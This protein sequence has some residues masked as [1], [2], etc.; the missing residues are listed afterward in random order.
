[1]TALSSEAL[2]VIEGRHSDP[3]H[4]LGLYVE[5]DTPVVRAFL[6]DAEDV[7]AID[8]TGRAGELQRIH[9]AGLFAGNLA[10]GSSHYHLQARFG[11]RV[12]QFEEAS[13]L[14]CPIS[15]FTSSARAITSS[16]TTNSAP[17]L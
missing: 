10:N 1:M 5:G 15:I 2:A 14:S 9:E 8:K 12:E 17:I 3:F 6:P 16:S 4:Y 13:R 7:V 11:D